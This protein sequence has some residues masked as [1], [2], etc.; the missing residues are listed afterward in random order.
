MNFKKILMPIAKSLLWSEQGMT[1]AVHI[2][3]GKIN[4]R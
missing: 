4:G 3:N 2:L 1:K